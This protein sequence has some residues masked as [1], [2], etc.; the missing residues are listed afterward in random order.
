ML[1][2]LIYHKNII[3]K[4]YQVKNGSLTIFF[5]YKKGIEHG[6]F[7]RSV[8]GCDSTNKFMK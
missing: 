2:I 6:M 1:L 3:E 5:S 4:G 7:E 8:E